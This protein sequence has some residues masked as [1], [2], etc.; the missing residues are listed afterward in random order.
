[1]KVRKVVGKLKQKQLV[2]VGFTRSAIN[3]KEM[4]LQ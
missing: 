2:V 4:V 3:L 1:M